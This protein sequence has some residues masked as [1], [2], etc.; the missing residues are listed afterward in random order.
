MSITNTSEEK[1]LEERLMEAKSNIEL[2]RLGQELAA[3][4]LLA[5]DYEIIERSWS[6]DY[7]EADIIAKD[8]DGTLC[9]ID[10]E[11]RKGEDAGFSEKATTK[12]KKKMFEQIA[13]NYVFNNEFD[14]MTQIRFDSIEI[15]VLDGVNRAV[16]RHNIAKFH[17]T[18]SN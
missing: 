10:V 17:N 4:Y 8:E 6:C 7:G 11:T 9:F 13:L 2:S 12:K 18:F 14:S 5:H 15:C 1:T 16:L 3:R